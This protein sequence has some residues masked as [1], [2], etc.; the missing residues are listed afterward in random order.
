MKSLSRVQLLATPWTAAYQAPLSMDF[1]GKSTGVGCHW[2]RILI[3]DKMDCLT[4]THFAR[5]FFI[6]IFLKGQLLGKYNNFKDML[7]TRPQNTWSK[8]DRMEERLKKNIKEIMV[9]VAFSNL[10]MRKGLC[11]LLQLEKYHPMPHCRHIVFKFQVHSVLLYPDT[12]GNRYLQL[13]SSF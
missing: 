12:S 11:E 4:H 5:D 1:P 10:K 13:I 6:M 8:T 9:E 2:S 3:E 7:T